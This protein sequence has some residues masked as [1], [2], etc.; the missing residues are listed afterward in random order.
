MK[1]KLL[2]RLI[3]TLKPGA[4]PYEVVD[5]EIPGFSIRVESSGTKTYYLRYRLPN[6]TRA[7]LKLG[8]SS[9]LTAEQA[10]DAAK[11][12]AGKAALGINPVAVRK[13]SRKVKTLGEFIEQHYGPV[14]VAKRRRGQEMLDRLEFC[15]ESYYARRLDEL[16]HSD[17]EKWRAQALRDGKAVSTVNKEIT[18]L[19]SVLNR[20]VEWDFL[21]FNPLSKIKALTVDRAGIVRYLTDDEEKALLAALETREENMRKER[22]SANDWRKDR[23]YE[24]LPNLRKMVF[25]D[26]LRPVVLLSLNT[27][28]RRGEVFHLRWGDI[29]FGRASLAV[30]GA[31]AKTGTTRHVPLN[32]VALDALKNWSA[33]S[34]NTSGLV[35]TSAKTGGKLDNLNTSWE[36]VLADA[37]IDQFRWHDMRHHF[38]S[39]LVMAGVDLN[40]VRELLG[41]SDLKMTLRYAHLSPRIK[42][43]AVER[44]VSPN[45]SR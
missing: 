40:T 2:A 12:E 20:A 6:G 8:A 36:G 1:A 27:G 15:F 25:A 21:A 10:R 14:W 3:S 9:A 24:L 7:R 11:A 4:G 34:G 32:S 43:E 45:T 23:G 18:L 19:K 22:D 26:A 17:I 44:I 42:Q 39:Q 41:H 30:A 16:R 33:Q 38:A 29:D 28:L 5:T 37:K 35:F 13:E 31:T